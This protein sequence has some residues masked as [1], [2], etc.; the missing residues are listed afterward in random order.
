M[1]IKENAVSAM[2]KTETQWNAKHYKLRIEL[3][4]HSEDLVL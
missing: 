2:A 4:Q 1:H 3:N